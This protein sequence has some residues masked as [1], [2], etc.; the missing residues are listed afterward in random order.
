MIKKVGSRG[1]R[2]F[3][4][5]GGKIINDKYMIVYQNPRWIKNEI[6]EI[7]KNIMTSF[8]LIPTGIIM[9]FCSILLIFLLPFKCIPSLLIKSKIDD[10]IPKA[11]FKNSKTEV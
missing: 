5:Y 7:P 11:E 4:D 8:M 2:M 6:K 10:E 1:W 3:K 9:L